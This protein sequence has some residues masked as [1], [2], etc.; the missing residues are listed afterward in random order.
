MKTGKALLANMKKEG[1]KA[2]ETAMK[3]AHKHKKTKK[4]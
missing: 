3:K 4:N 1:K 2:S